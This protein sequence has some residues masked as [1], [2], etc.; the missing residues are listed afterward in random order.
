MPLYSAGP[1]IYVRGQQM[2]RLVWS[3]AVRIFS[4]I[5]FPMARSKNPTDLTNVQCM[6][7]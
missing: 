7:C 2:R 4:L 5:P 6:S 1:N 3:F